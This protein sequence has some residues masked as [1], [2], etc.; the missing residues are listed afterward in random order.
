MN[1]R[2][3]RIFPQRPHDS[4]GSMIWNWSCW[5]SLICLLIFSDWLSEA[6]ISKDRESIST[7]RVSKD[8]TTSS[9]KSS[10]TTKSGKRGSR[11]F[12]V[13]RSHFSMRYFKTPRILLPSP[14]SSSNGSLVTTFL[15]RTSA[16][17][18]QS[19]FRSTGSFGL[20]ATNKADSSKS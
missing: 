14:I 12:I 18:T 1:F 5:N 17:R 19:F 13:S 15:M 11:S 8:C 2:I 6:V 16:T 7:A 10:M 3:T 20:S 9:L 4:F